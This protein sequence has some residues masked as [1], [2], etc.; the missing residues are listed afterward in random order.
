MYVCVHAQICVIYHVTFS[1]FIWYILKYI[2]YSVCI[3]FFEQNSGLW[4]LSLCSLPVQL[5]FSH[6]SLFLKLI[7]CIDGA[8][9]IL[10]KL[11]TWEFTCITCFVFMR[12]ICLIYLLI[13]TELWYPYISITSLTN[14]YYMVLI[15]SLAYLME[16]ILKLDYFYWA[17]LN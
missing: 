12:N 16:T 2:D 15:I 11:K 5:K 14:W 4:Y 10:C 17:N 13:G 6:V 3:Y 8:G 7:Y 1:F 9:L